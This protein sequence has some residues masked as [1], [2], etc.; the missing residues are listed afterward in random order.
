LALFTPVTVVP[1]ARVG[2][3]LLALALALG[4]SFA[5]IARIRHKAFDAIADAEATSGPSASMKIP[6]RKTAEVTEKK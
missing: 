2:V 1:A 6:P 5:T 4:Q 3:V